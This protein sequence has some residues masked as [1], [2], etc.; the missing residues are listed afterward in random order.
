MNIENKVQKALG[1][2]YPFSVKI[3]VKME[4]YG[5]Q[6]ALRLTREIVKFLRE[7]YPDYTF[8]KGVMKNYH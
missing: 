2:C 4:T 3:Q 1:M 7:Q 5:R 8:K 6:E